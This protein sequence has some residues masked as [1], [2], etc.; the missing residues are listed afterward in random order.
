MSRNFSCPKPTTSKK[1]HALPLVVHITPSRF[2][3]GKK[4]NF[5]HQIK[6]QK[7]LYRLKFRFSLGKNFHNISLFSL[8]MLCQSSKRTTPDGLHLWLEEV[9]R[10]AVSYIVLVYS[11]WERRQRHTSAYQGG[12][13]QGNDQGTW[14]QWCH[15]R[16]KSP[17]RNP[18]W[19]W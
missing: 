7:K 13:R 15:R 8:K 11:N 2:I 9:V 12:V 17:C 10:A 6:I 14:C 19:L 16:H 1:C 18:P 3:Q 4:F 5:G